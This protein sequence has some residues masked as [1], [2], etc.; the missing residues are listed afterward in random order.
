LQSR[1]HGDACRRHALAIV[2]WFCNSPV[3]QA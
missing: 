3:T 2:S 1:K